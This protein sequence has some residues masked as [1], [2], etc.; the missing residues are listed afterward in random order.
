MFLERSERPGRSNTS[1]VHRCALS[2]NSVQTTLGPS[3]FLTTPTSRKYCFDKVTELGLRCL[4][5]GSYAVVL[6]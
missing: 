2:P 4:V 3:A 1:Q 5:V 6:R